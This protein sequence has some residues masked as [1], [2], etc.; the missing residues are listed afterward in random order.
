MTLIGA[1]TNYPA[2][3]AQTTFIITV[4]DPCLSA[5]I[6]TSPHPTITTSVYVPSSSQTSLWYDSVSGSAAQ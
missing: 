1:I 2:V 3:S 4:E 5:T 6:I